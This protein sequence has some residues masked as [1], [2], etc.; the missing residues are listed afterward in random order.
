MLTKDD[1]GGGGGGKGTSASRAKKEIFNDLCF[2]ESKFCVLDRPPPPPPQENN[3]KK[4]HIFLIKW[5]HSF[6][7]LPH[8][9]WKKSNEENRPVA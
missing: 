4:I 7:P 8:F 9:P 6:A 2:M 5:E 3:N 1:W